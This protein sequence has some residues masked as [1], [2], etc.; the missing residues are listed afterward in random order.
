MVK[1]VFV[2]VL[3]FLCFPIIPT[4][5]QDDNPQ[6]RKFTT[7]DSLLTFNYPDGWLI[8]AEADDFGGGFFMMANAPAALATMR[9]NGDSGQN[10][11]MPDGEIGIIVMRPAYLNTL[12]SFEADTTPA[13]V[14]EQ[15]FG[16]SPEFDPQDIQTITL[17]ERP[18]AR[19]DAIDDKSGGLILAIDFGIGGMYVL[20]ASTTPDDV[21]TFTPIVLDIAES[22]RFGGD[23]HAILVHDAPVSES[24]ISPNGQFLATRT[25]DT[26]NNVSK[27]RIWDIESSELLYETDGKSMNWSPDGKQFVVNNDPQ[28]TRIIDTT[29]FE[30]VLL[31][32][33]NPYTQWT[34]DGTKLLT[35]DYARGFVTLRDAQSGETI[36]FVEAKTFSPYLRLNETVIQTNVLSTTNGDNF[37]AFWD[38]Q[39]GDSLHKIERA[40]NAIWNADESRVMAATDDR[41]I[42]VYE[43]PSGQEV[44]SIAVETDKEILALD[45]RA[46]ETLISANIGSCPPSGENCTLTLA[47]WDAQTGELVRE[48]AQDEPYRYALWRPDGAQVLTLSRD[49]DRAVLWDVATGEII[50]TFDHPFGY[51][52]GGLWNPD[53]SQFF[54]WSDEN[55]VRLWDA[56]SGKILMSLPH[57]T[58]VKRVYWYD[59]QSL[60]FTETTDGMMRVWDS[61]SGYPLVRLGHANK[62]AQDVFVFREWNDDQRYLMTRIMSDG[63]VR[64]WDI[65]T[66]V[67]DARAA[68]LAEP[69][70]AEEHIVRGTDAFNTRDYAQAIVEYT[71][72]I[73]LD[74]DLAR[75]YSDRGASYYLSG[76]TN[77]ALADITRAI[78][79]LPT[80]Q[81][82]YINRADI[83]RNAQAYDRALEDYTRAIDLEP[84]ATLHNKRGVVHSNLEQF[85]AAEDDFTRAIELDPNDAIFYGNRG[86]VRYKQGKAFYEQALEDLKQYKTLSGTQAQQFYLDIIA[87]IEAD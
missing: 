9:Q 70:N 44:L 39:T 72:A 79:L 2:I 55:I 77:R 56:E 17:A 87:S 15:L 42:H 29:T 74:P 7:Y 84:S 68:I 60:I 35:N 61:A 41:K 62:T 48:I 80:Y 47:V 1:R 28:Q 38:A 16:L 12:F 37:I 6:W 58:Q 34:S 20:A 11:P 4:H 57:E 54:T 59:D 25:S 75:A 83:Y 63:F 73:A 31:I 14:I 30:D 46:D 26:Q 71:A 78:Q 86:Y 8:D 85:A 53:G 27:V 33:A 51:V 19:L 13:D 24:H 43:M 81:Q 67:S 52:Q 22:M 82:A 21:E 64:V 69:I 66:L 65:K 23:A 76:D 49:P 40:D 3:T 32:P 45:W 5:A 50:R 36:A 10:I 18:A